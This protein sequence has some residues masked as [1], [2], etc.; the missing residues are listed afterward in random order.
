MASRM[1]EQRSTVAQSVG[2]T[3]IKDDKNSLDAT[4]L[5]AVSDCSAQQPLSP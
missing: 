3:P 1:E 5:P 2:E 4:K